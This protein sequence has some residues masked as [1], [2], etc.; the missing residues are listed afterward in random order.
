[1]LIDLPAADA[2]RE[3]IAIPLASFFS[4]FQ[5][6]FS[7]D[8]IIFFDPPILAHATLISATVSYLFRFCFFADTLLFF[9]ADA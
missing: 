5:I 1:M 3:A 8:A 2:R 4:F 7:S 6:A 9:A